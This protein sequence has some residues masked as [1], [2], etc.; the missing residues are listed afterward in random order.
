ME[1]PDHIYCISL[2]RANRT[3]DAY[4]EFAKHG[5]GDVELV[6]AIDCLGT[7]LRGCE[8]CALTHQMVFKDIVAKGYQRAL[9]LEDDALF[10]DN[11]LEKFAAIQEL[12]D[13]QMFYF[14]GTLVNATGKPIGNSAKINN[15]LCGH[16]YMIRGAALLEAIKMIPERPTQPHDCY[17][18][19]LQKIY[20]T[21]I[22]IPFLILQ[23]PGHSSIEGRFMDYTEF[24]R[25]ESNRIQNQ[26]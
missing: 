8:A 26:L 23:K 24:M 12:E 5:I 6:Y 21:Y 9:I 3:E 18:C 11:F 2:K 17:L 13:W 20:P 14:G 25:D 10:E 4:K 15:A 19:E 7:E 16:A 22:S 1:A